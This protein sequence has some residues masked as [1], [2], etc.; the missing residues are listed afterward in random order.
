[1]KEN[2]Q[3]QYEA[4]LGDGLLVA[5]RL[6]DDAGD[7]EEFK[8]KIKEDMRFREA[9]GIRCGFSNE[10]LNKVGESLKMILCQTMRVAIVASIADT[11]GFGKTRIQR[12]ID[13][14]DKLC[15]YMDAGWLSWMDM[16]NTIKG[17]FGW[18]LSIDSGPEI[19]KHYERPLA[20]DMY[21]AADLIRDEEWM[22]VLNL[23]GFRE[24]VDAE[25]HRCVFD[26]DEPLIEWDNEYQKIQAYDTICGMLFERSRR[27]K[28]ARA[29][30][31]PA[32]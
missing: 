28:K 32:F 8:K 2:T 25:G 13:T 7:I 5:L 26:K 10:E 16:I 14:F 1:M 24:G 11:Y 9:T 17:R 27:Q 18:D 12:C 29:G 20:E 21:E 23:A 6:A 4:G 31:K 3:N 15:D 19:L 22:E 30:A